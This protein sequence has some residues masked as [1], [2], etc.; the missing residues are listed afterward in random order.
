MSVYK[1]YIYSDA[2][3]YKAKLVGVSGFLIFRSSVEHEAGVLPLSLIRTVTFQEKTNIRAELK[4]IL[5]AL[6]T[7][8]AEIKRI[9]EKE[10]LEN[11]EVNLYTDCQTVTQLLMRREK[12]E[13]SSFLSHRKKTI[14]P[15]ADLYKTFFEL[16]DRLRPRVFW[17]KGHSPQRGQNLIQKNFRMIDQIV[18]KELRAKVRDPHGWKNLPPD[19]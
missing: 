13:A 7:A 15:N 12:L 2:S 1:F 5:S 6:E 3:F 14:L 9:G 8:T 10:V 16:Y 19:K 17:V 18:R 11:I 4:G